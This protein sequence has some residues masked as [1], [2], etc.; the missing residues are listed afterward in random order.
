[1][2]TLRRYFIDTEFYPDAD[3]HS[4]PIS[5]G[6]IAQ[7]DKGPGLYA[8][9]AE[10]NKAACT[11]QWVNL[12]VIPKLDDKAPRLSRPQMADALT[13]YLN[14]AETIEF[15]ARNGSYDFYH[16]CQIYGSMGHLFDRLDKQLGI[17]KVIFRDIN[18]LHRQAGNPDLPKPPDDLAHISIVDATW[19]RDLFR[20]LE[21]RAALHSVRPAQIA[22]TITTGIRAWLKGPL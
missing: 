5:F 2:E 13:N 14:P 9:A 8:I 18:E 11:H 6:L 21:R 4:H 3:G 15:W 16:L 17:K 1:M 22:R 10:F 20:E 12:H 7:D 19:D